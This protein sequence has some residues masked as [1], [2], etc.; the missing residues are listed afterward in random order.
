MKKTLGNKL[1]DLMTEKNITGKQLASEINITEGTISKILTG[2][3]NN[4]KSDTIIALAK[5]FDV[6]TDYLLGMSNYKTHKNANIGEITGLTDENVDF[7]I[8]TLRKTQENKKR[9]GAYWATKGG[10]EANTYMINELLRLSQSECI[11]DKLAWLQRLVESGKSSMYETISDKENTVAS[12]GNSNAVNGF[13]FAFWFKDNIESRLI[14]IQNLLDKVIMQYLQ[15][16]ELEQFYDDVVSKWFSEH[17][18]AI[19][20]DLPKNPIYKG[21]IVK[22]VEND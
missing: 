21:K 4:P 12:D 19:G 9:F 10:F 15:Y 18:N 3:N 7:L 2:Q 11:F 20:W 14:E 22:T 17:G 1:S 13:E 5:Y 16:D 8:N 6:S